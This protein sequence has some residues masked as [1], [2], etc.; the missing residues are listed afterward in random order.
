MIAN[1]HKQLI[2]SVFAALAQGDT[3]AFADAM[4]DDFSWT[5]SGHGP[6]SRTWRGK[7]RVRRELMAPLFAQFSGTYRNRAT[8]ILA[9]GD[10]I[11]VEC[12]GEVMTQAGRRYDNHYCYVIEMRDG[13]MHALTE[14]MDTALAEAVLA[15]PA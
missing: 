6:W 11:V 15:A 12:R 1:T 4:A 3:Q 8:R 7:H 2:E 10:V 13:Q 5:I 14:Y 9:D